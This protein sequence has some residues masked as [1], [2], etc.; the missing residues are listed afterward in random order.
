MPSRSLRRTVAALSLAALLL[1]IST[2]HA[3]QRQSRPAPANPARPAAPAT[4][5]NSATQISPIL[6]AI[7][8]F[9]I[10]AGMQIDGNG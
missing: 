10:D 4:P 7:V 8:Q 3:A 2:L 1:P 9:F 5:A 6:G